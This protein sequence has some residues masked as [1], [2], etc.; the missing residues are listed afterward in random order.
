VVVNQATGREEG[1]AVFSRL[2]KTSARFLG[3]TLFDLGHL[4]HDPQVG[5]AARSRRPV[6]A[7]SRPQK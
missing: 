4:P 3:R 6:V 2:A 7:A 1:R 5:I